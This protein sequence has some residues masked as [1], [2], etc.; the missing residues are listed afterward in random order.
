MRVARLTLRIGASRLLATAL[1]LA[2]GAAIACAA[3]FLPGWW[4][5]AIATTAV[6]ASLAFHLRRDALQLSGAA[7]TELTL[8]E[9]A[10]CEFT[11]KNGATFTGIVQGSS[12]VAPVLIVVNVR[13]PTRKGSRSVILLPDS[14]AT[15]DL[16]SVRV[17][18]R[19]HMP[20][21]HDPAS[22]PL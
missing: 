1:L 20:L 17:W 3:I 10:Q 15:Q 16:R 8:R 19:H 21:D 5:P 14:A 2:H 13:A 6:T 4:M 18:L 9:G 12:F 11:M 7:I 22:G